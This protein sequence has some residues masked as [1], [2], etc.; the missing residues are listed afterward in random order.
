MARRSA[1]S[2]FLA[3]PLGEAL[4]SDVAI[5]GGMEV[6]KSLL[7]HNKAAMAIQQP[8]AQPAIPQASQQPTPPAKTETT[9]LADFHKTLLG[10]TEDQIRDLTGWMENLDHAHRKEIATWSK[11]ELADLIKLPTDLRTKLISTVTGPTPTEE[12]AKIKKW[13]QDH[14]PK[15]INDESRA[16][17]QGW[18]DWAD[19]ILSK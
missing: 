13:M 17:L 16:I 19:K 5:M 1:L 14:M 15:V 4:L 3:S 8:P 18:E 6:I 7:R 2:D 12:I 10:M 11:T 9:T